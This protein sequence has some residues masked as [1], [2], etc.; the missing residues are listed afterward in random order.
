MQFDVYSE[1]AER[2][3]EILKPLLPSSR[4]GD[5]LR[6]WDCRYA[7]SSEG[8]FL[9]EQVYE[10]L[11]RDVFG[12]GGLGKDVIDYLLGQTGVLIAF[13]VNFD[14]VLLSEKSVWFGAESRE[15]IHQRA[16]AEALSVDPQ[17]WGKGRR[18]M[19]RHLLLG[20]RF[21]ALLGFDRG[22]VTAIG[23][24]ATIHQ[25]QIY[26]SAKRTST[27][28]P[29]FRMITDLGDD[30]VYSNLAGGPSD[31][32]F[33]RWYCSDLKNWLSGKYKSISADAAQTRLR[34]R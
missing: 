16:A 20:G 24:R 11:C 6:N 18:Y 2:F 27:Y 4:Q 3:M 14:R 34:F 33:S 17:P 21:P 25:G 32:R 8:A 5:V 9:F 29:A 30:A 12:E 23:G 15:Q 7:A 1:Q 26:Q 22:P 19:L 31:R 28:V 10:Q 13:Y